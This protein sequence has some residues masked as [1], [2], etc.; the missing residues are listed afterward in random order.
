[1]RPAPSESS[2]SAATGTLSITQNMK[3]IR[4]GSEFCSAKTA[5]DAATMATMR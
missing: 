2:T 5:T 1:M 3:R 4:V